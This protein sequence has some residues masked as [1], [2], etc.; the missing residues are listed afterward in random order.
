MKLDSFFFSSYAE[1]VKLFKF[2]ISQLPAEKVL[3]F[4]RVRFL[5]DHFARRREGSRQRW[6]YQIQELL[7]I[8]VRRSRDFVKE[9]AFLFWRGEI[10]DAATFLVPQMDV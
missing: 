9:T 2:V 8:F 5:P 7:P 4:L 3:L 1:W 10:I 6:N